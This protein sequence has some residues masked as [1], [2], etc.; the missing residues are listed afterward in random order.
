[1]KVRVN[2]KFDWV[3]PGA[4]IMVTFNVGQIWDATEV[5]D[6]SFEIRR[7]NVEITVSKFAIE[8]YFDEIANAKSTSEKE[9]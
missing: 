9:G 4:P 5:T 8:R 7:Q 3:F 2:R 6:T 1:M